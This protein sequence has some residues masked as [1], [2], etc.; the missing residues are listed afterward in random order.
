MSAA[1]S[2]SQPPPART[3]GLRSWALG[4]VALAAL[5]GA[6]AGAWWWHRPAVEPP[7]VPDMPDAEVRLAT[8]RARQKVLDHP[9]DAKAWGDLGTTFLVH[10]FE[11]EADQCFAHAARLDPADARW[12]YGRAMI[13]LKRDPDH[14][15]AYL[16]QAAAC[17]DS[18]PE[19]RS[20]VR[21]QL[22]QAVLARRELDEAESLFQDELRREPGNA[23]ATFGLGLVAVARGH[24]RA[25]VEYLSAVRA[26]PY[27]RKKSAA[28]LAA[29]AATRNDAAA[30]ADWEKQAADLP[31]DSPW[32][33][34]FVDM[35]RDARAGPRY[36]ERKLTMLEADQHFQEAAD[37]YL[38]QIREQPTARAYLGA[39]HNLA[40]L[41]DY[42]RALPLLREGIRR[43]PD[44][45]QAHY[46]LALA[47]FTRA[48]REVQQAPASDPVKEWLREAVEHARRTA[49]LKPDDASAYLIW[50]LALKYLGEP[51][52]A[53][54]PL[55]KGVVCRPEQFDLQL[56]LGDALLQTGQDREAETYL[57][58]ARRLNPND[59]RPGQA[60]ERLHP[61]KK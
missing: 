2:T 1:K 38:A 55:R 44:S 7:P 18:W 52:A 17:A 45:P 4:G 47:Q 30:Q 19:G 21:L 40:R 57:E 29:L 46:T 14:A 13:V 22:A 60:L 49:E 11:H 12:R 32:P 35:L 23:R 8:E 56:A 3:G 25:A 27:A 26:N 41:G 34:P 28:Q 43:D 54:E 5:A 58:N 6:A 59:P 31:E 15:I 37:I 51:A 33:D 10:S 24:D 36:W 42:E 48:E 9:H 53:I 20:T 16:R 61:K 39:G 50:G